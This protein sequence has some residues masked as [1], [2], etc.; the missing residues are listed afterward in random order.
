MKRRKSHDSYNED[1]IV[2]DGEVVHT[3]LMLADHALRDVVHRAHLP[4]AYQRGYVTVA[5]PRS[6]IQDC[7]ALWYKLRDEMQDEWRA[8]PRRDSCCS[9][10]A[11]VQDQPGTIGFLNPQLPW[12]TG[13]AEGQECMTDDKR[14][15][16]LVKENGKYVCRAVEDFDAQSVDAAQ[17]RRDQ[18]YEQMVR[19][20]Q[21]AWQRW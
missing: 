18:A 9:G 1:D 15:G 13:Q 12:M 7:T 20:M 17:A 21:T 19:D 8:W 5:R 14:Q 11:D 6:P 10:C 4:M 2:Q 16:R 3:P